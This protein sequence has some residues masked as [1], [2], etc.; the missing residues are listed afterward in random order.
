MERR[1]SFRGKRINIASDEGT[2]VDRA[3]LS[4]QAAGGELRYVPVPL[5]EVRKQ[6][7]DFAKMYDGF[8]RVGYSVH[9]PKLD[10]YY[11]VDMEI[12]PYT[13]YT[14]AQMIACEGP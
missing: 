12:K 2:P 1:N 4:S 11:S 13:N 9:I 6:S 14:P 3:R 7:E 10:P 5:D 8:N